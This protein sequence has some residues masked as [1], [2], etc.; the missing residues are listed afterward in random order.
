MLPIFVDKVIPF[1]E[2]NPYELIKKIKPDVLVK[3]GDYNNKKI[4]G[5][6]LVNEVVLIEFVEG[7]STTNFIKK[8]RS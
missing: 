8:I 2:D 3:G 7:Y 5:S 4:I 6:E 1:S